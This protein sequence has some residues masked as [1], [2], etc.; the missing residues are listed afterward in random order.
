[1][2]SRVNRRRFLSQAGITGLVGTGAAVGTRSKALADDQRPL[3][4]HGAWSVAVTFPGAPTESEQGIIAFTV[5]GIVIESNTENRYAGLGSWAQAG[6]GGFVYGWRE[7][8][9]LS[10]GT[11]GLVLHVKQTATFTSATTFTSTG[12]GT[13]FDPAGNLLETLTSNIT[14]TRYGIGQ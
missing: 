7:Q 11:L 14:G 9:F 4:P 6:G 3:T 2:A 8:L 13:A 5:D 1:M 10:D 12:T